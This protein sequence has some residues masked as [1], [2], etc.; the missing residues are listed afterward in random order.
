MDMHKYYD[1][2]CRERTSRE[3]S[4]LCCFHPQNDRERLM[5]ETAYRRGYCQ[6]WA[7]SLGMARP[8][9]DRHL[10]DYLLPWRWSRHDG[11]FCHPPE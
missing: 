7:G 10:R 6:G 8:M 9:A 5:V 3:P 2:E 1:L 11:E 4:H